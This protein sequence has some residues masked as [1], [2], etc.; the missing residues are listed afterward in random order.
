[1]HSFQRAVLCGKTMDTDYEL[2]G[3]PELLETSLY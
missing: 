3:K 2:I 1:M